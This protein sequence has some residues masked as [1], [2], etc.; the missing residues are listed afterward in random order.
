M[1]R[2]ITIERDGPYQVEPRPKSVWICGCGLSRN[3]PFCDGSHVQARNEDKTTLYEYN[4]HQTANPIGPHTPCTDCPASSA[5][6][7]P[8]TP[9]ITAGRRVTV[10]TLTAPDDRAAAFRLRANTHQQ[11]AST[12]ADM[13]DDLDDRS[14]LFGAFRDHTLIGTVRLTIGLDNFGDYTRLYRLDDTTPHP[15]QTSI[16]TR[17]VVAPQ[18]RGSPA[19]LHLSIAAYET[20]LAHGVRTNYIDCQPDS[21]RM[22]QRLGY[23]RHGDDINHPRFGPSRLL[24]LELHDQ[25]HLRSVRSPFL[26]ALTRHTQ[27]QTC[28]TTVP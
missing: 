17:L 15:D 25:R 23:I 2:R 7:Q 19:A 27:S 21:E 10:R 9:T 22:F 24:R 20:G 26:G 5:D 11:T 14:H 3:P 13:P 12:D 28:A 16:T 8:A 1:A 18:H 4:A 6:T